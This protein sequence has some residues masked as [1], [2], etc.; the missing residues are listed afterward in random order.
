M[1]DGMQSVA[2]ANNA[3]SRKRGLLLLSDARSDAIHGVDHTVRTR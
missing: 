2:S 3:F 1:R